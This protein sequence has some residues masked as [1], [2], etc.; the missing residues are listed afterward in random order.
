MAVP[1]MGE[2]K[3][4]LRIASCGGK[5]QAWRNP[6]SAP[7]GSLGAAGR[8]PWQQPGRVVQRIIV[9]DDEPTVARLLQ[10]AL[11][12]LS[13]CDIGVAA[14]GEQALRFLNERLFDLLITDYRLPGMEGIVLAGQV[15]MFHPR[16]EIVMIPP[17]SMTR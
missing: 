12:D 4:S 5:E 7:A 11:Q 16:T 9:V 1:E 13:D 14:S 10:A 17:L 15:R 8:G 6:V 2:G 3:A